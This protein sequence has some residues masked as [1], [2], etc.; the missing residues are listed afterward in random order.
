MPMVLFEGDQELKT[1]NAFYL[2]VLR[3]S[4]YMH[5]KHNMFL[6]AAHEPDDIDRALEA[7][8]GAFRDIVTAGILA[9]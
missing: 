2:A 3:R 9:A 4:V 7:V 6:C 5:P 1:A 8:D